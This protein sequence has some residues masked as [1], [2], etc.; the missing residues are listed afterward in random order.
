MS[1]ARWIL[2]DGGDV[3]PEN[4]EHSREFRVVREVVVPLEHTRDD[5]RVAKIEPVPGRRGQHKGIAH[6]LVGFPPE[7]DFKAEVVVF[8]D[9]VITEPKRQSPQHRYDLLAE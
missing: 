3:G 8:G 5:I 9:V 7:R 2:T 4:V 1:L 6:L